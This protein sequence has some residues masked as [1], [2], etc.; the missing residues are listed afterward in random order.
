M[1]QLQAATRV[2]VNLPDKQHLACECGCTPDTHQPDPGSDDVL[3]GVC[4]CGAWTLYHA[5]GGDWSAV[6]EYRLGPVPEILALTSSDLV[7][8]HPSDDEA[9]EVEPSRAARTCA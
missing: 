6:V 4:E 7:E 1:V 2:L 8:V 5:V 9:L 3:L